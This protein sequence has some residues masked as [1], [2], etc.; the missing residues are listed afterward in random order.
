MD[1]ECAGQRDSCQSRKRDK[2]NQNHDPD[3]KKVNKKKDSKPS[4]ERPSYTS[5]KHAAPKSNDRIRIIIGICAFGLAIMIFSFTHKRNLNKDSDLSPWQ[6]GMITQNVK[7]QL[8]QESD[9]N[10]AFMSTLSAVQLRELIRNSGTSLELNDAD[11][12]GDGDQ[13]PLHGTKAQ[14]MRDIWSSGADFL[15]LVSNGELGRFSFYCFTGQHHLVRT[16]L[17]NATRSQRAQLLEGRESLVRNTPLMMCVNGIN[18]LSSTDKARFRSDHARVAK[19]LLAHGARPDARDV[20]GHTALYL[21]AADVSAQDAL[22]LV[23][24]LV[25]AGAD[26]NAPN[27]FGATAL[28]AAV[29]GGSQNAIAALLSHGADPHFKCHDGVSPLSMERFAPNGRVYQLLLSPPRQPRPGQGDAK[30]QGRGHKAAGPPHGLLDREAAGPRPALTRK[31]LL[32]R[33]VE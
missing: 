4:N 8:I 18:L 14:I 5:R 17:D 13:S 22:A 9:A 32:R 7:E 3:N 2:R 27:R 10:R 1:K 31:A 19:L 26:I 23:A 11:T 15:S 16:M 20:A 12:L 6:T 28:H 24:P 21:A 29:M 30:A 25:A 33:A